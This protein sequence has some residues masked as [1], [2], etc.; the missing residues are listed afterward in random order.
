MAEQIKLIFPDG[1]EK[2]FDHGTTG[3]DVAQSISPGLRK[4]AVAIK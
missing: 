2:L 3:E 4:Q 1:S